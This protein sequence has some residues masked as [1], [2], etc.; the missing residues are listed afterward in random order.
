MESAKAIIETLHAKFSPGI[1]KVDHSSDMPV[2]TV[3]SSIIH[4]LIRFLKE[5]PAMGFS[6]LTTLCSIHYPDDPLPL[7][8]V[9]HF[10]NL[11]KNLRIRIRTFVP[12]EDP[13]LPTVTDLFSAANWMEREAY[14][15]YGIVFTGHPNLKRIL[16]VEYLD[17]FPMRKEYPLEDPTREDK[18]DR[19]FGR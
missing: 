8:V 7:G 5:E 16:N 10:H 19:Y 15:F 1:L 6:F 17:Y 3:E 4:D 13:Q 14:D 2:V 11:E 12:S 9:Y 18:D